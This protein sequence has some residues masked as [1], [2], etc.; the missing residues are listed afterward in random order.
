M[1]SKPVISRSKKSN[2]NQG[3]AS[4]SRIRQLRLPKRTSFFPGRSRAKVENSY[5]YRLPLNELPPELLD[6]VSRTLETNEI[7]S[8]RLTQKGI[9]QNVVARNTTGA[10]HQNCSRWKGYAKQKKYGR[11]EILS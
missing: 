8:L 3:N 2:V 10:A 6:L 7:D 9:R 1:A 11:F 5:T 4:K